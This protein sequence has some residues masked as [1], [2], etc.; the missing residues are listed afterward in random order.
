M[1]ASSADS[2]PSCSSF[3]SASVTAAVG[4]LSVMRFIS[5]CSKN[6]LMRAMTA[7]VSTYGVSACGSV[8][9]TS[10]VPRLM[11]RYFGWITTRVIVLI[12]CC[13]L[14]F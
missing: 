7:T 3:C 9:W 13:S 5:A 10:F 4:L 14:F 2:K 11:L 8:S 1:L 6:G 12:C